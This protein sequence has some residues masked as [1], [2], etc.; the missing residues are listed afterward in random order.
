MV[1]YGLSNRDSVRFPEENA[2]ALTY[3]CTFSSIL[4]HNKAKK[5]IATSL[6]KRYTLWNWI[7][8]RSLKGGAN[9]LPNDQ[10]HH[11]L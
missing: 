5:N 8:V 11:L 1:N 7:L 9:F 6:F 3:T 2:F 4:L 10:W